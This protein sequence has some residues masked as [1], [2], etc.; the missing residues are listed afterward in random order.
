MI[1]KRVV[2]F[3][4]FDPLHEGHRD[5]FCQAKRLGNYLLVV[6]ARNSSIRVNK[7]REPWQSEE[8]RVGCIEGLDEVDEV[9]LGKEWP[10]N[11]KYS[12]LSELEFDV[13]VLGYDQ[14]PSDV[15]VLKE[16]EKRGKGNVEVVRL[17]AYRPEVYKSGKVRKSKI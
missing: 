16:L 14:K 13:L 5:F 15:V 10:L 7:R 9:L 4:V 17:K 12:L 2:A 8:A 1:D 3:G 11:D 6:V